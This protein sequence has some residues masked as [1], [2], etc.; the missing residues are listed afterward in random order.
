MVM[1][2]RIWGLMRE[3]LGLCVFTTLDVPV[4]IDG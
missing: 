2:L 4:I 3:Y 1:L